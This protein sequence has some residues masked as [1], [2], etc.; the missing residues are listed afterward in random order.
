MRCEAGLRPLARSRRRSSSGRSGSA[1]SRQLLE[2]A[3]RD[4]DA[5]G[6]RGVAR[7][8]A[9]LLDVALAEPASLPFGPEGAFAVLHGLYR[10][11][12]NLARDRPLALLV[13]DAHWADA[14]SL[15]F[16]A[17]LAGRI[18]HEPV[19]LVVAARPPGEP[20]GAAVAALL[21]EAG[22]PTL[23]RPD[24]AQRR[25]RRR[26]SSAAPSPRR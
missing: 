2:P 4:G 13:D 12:A 18:R 17:Y 16:L 22:A 1:S 25:R 5:R 21:A 8:A 3:V 14:A 9:A 19:L 20:G 6:V 7:Y 23:L 15:R 11:T 26:S 10:L 24:G